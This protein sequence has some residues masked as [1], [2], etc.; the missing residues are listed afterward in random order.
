MLFTLEGKQS[1]RRGPYPSN[2]SVTASSI[3]LWQRYRCE[4]N[5]Q[6]TLWNS[7]K[8]LYKN[9]FWW[10]FSATK[11]PSSV[12]ACLLNWCYKI[13]WCFINLSVLTL[14]TAFMETV[15]FVIFKLGKCMSSQVLWKRPCCNM[16][17]ICGFNYL[18]CAPLVLGMFPGAC[19][20]CWLEVPWGSLDSY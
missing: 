6:I 13:G 11:E 3:A 7:L 19:L 2:S 10:C 18:Q 5:K 15:H 17:F 16:H 8:T 20:L 9:C 12:W 4:Q 1:N 14:S